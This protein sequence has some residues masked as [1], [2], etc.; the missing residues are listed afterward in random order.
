MQN[1]PSL[2]AAPPLLDFGI[3]ALGWACNDGDTARVRDLLNAGAD[4]NAPI[5]PLDGWTITPIIAAIEACSNSCVRALLEFGANPN[6]I[7]ED[8]GCHTGLIARCTPLLLADVTCNAPARRMLL[9]Y[10][11]D[12]DLAAQLGM[13]AKAF[14]PECN[15]RASYL[16]SGVR[17]QRMIRE[18]K[19]IRAIERALMRV[20]DLNEDHGML[21]RK[22][23]L[24]RRADAV[25][26]LLDY[27]TEPNLSWPISLTDYDDGST[28]IPQLLLRAGYHADSRTL[29]EAAR[30][31]RSD[32]IEL[33]I[34][35]GADPDRP[36]PDGSLLEP[37]PLIGA[38][39]CGQM[40]C[41]CALLDAGA[42]PDM[43]IHDFPW[44]DEL[45]ADFR[46]EI[47]YNENGGR[48]LIECRNCTPLMIACGMGCEEAVQ[49]LLHH[50]A[51]L[52]LKDSK[53]QSAGDYISKVSDLDK[54][55]R[56][57]KLLETRTGER[58]GIP[59]F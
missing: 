42:H 9:Q 53:G 3:T 32:I 39:L 56:I 21:L 36:T 7:C 17:V 8:F 37:T 38:I 4:P 55:Q 50:R 14:R 41:V 57:L 59:I 51:S 31:G 25:K 11:A 5:Y 28:E 20:R 45:D 48:G 12:P 26:L 52:S 33:A 18:G 46:N 54:R 13:S 27:G 10:G 15:M 40:D 23:C 6:A 19:S 44:L 29:L 49:S 24:A 30:V 35:F 1:A 47:W 16:A 22:A 2:K 58:E 34:A 43:V